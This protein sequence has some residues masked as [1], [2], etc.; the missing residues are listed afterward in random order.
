MKLREWQNNCLDAFVSHRNKSKRNTFVFEACPGAGKSHMAAELAWQMCN[1]DDKQVDLVIVVVPW[2][3]IQGDESNGMIKAFDQRGLVVRN[4]LMLRGARIV[5]QPVPTAFD[6]IITTYA[7]T[8]TVEGIETIQ[9]WKSKG[10]KISFV[11]DEIHHASEQKGEWGSL[12]EEAHE[13][14]DMTIVM[15]GTY[16]RTDQQPIKFVRYRDNGEPRTDCPPYKYQTAVADRVCRPVAFKFFDAELKCID[17][18]EGIE[19][20]AL[21]SIN[22]NDRRFG[23]VMREAFHPEGDVVR[24]MIHGIDEHLQ[25]TRRRFYSAGALITCRPGRD[26]NSEDKHVKQIAQKV[27]QYTGQEVMVVTH[28]DRNAQGKIDQFRNGTLPYLVAVNMISEGVDIPRLRAV[29]FMRYIRSEMMFRQIVGRTLRMTDDEDGTAAMGF[30]PK[31]DLMTQFARNME[32]EAIKGVRDWNCQV[33]GMYP[34]IC[35]CRICNQKPC[36]CPQI[37]GPPPPPIP[38]FDILET[39]VADA[40]GSVSV[41]EVSEAWITIAKAIADRSPHHMHANLVHLAHAFQMGY[42]MAAG[43][44]G[45][46]SEESTPLHRLNKARQRVNRLINK[47]TGKVY[48]GDFKACWIEEIMKPTGTDWT[49]I[50]NT[51]THPELERLGN[52]LEERLVTAYK[53]EGAK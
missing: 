4:R 6:A 37:P 44:P 2:K 24:H 10:L 21:S 30:M 26:D 51:W 43:S 19:T 35:H 53:N 14:S 38:G 9:L 32:G 20:H 41:D 15:S 22:E 27:R 25:R 33:C 16:F 12:A 45:N 3:S 13:S 34:C 7:E 48:E 42:P 50:K 11:F 28:N 18:I 49:T 5:Q 29:G 52:R 23:K 40:G 1:D 47:L 36:V 39:T 17:E 31:F 8:M 46:Q